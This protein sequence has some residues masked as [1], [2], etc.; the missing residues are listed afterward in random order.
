VRGGKN[1]N[2]MDRP[3]ARMSLILATIDLLCRGDREA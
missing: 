1:S 3:P 2:E